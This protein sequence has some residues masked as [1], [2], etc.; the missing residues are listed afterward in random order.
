MSGTHYGT[1]VLHVAPESAIGGPLALVHTGDMITLDVPQR[2]LHL[3]IDD[4]ELARRRAAW[5]PPPRKFERSYAKLYQQHVTQADAGCDFDFLET[6]TAQRV[7][8][9]DIF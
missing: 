3:H 2:R 8:E 1:C 6:G 7:P 5:T 9:P 4:A